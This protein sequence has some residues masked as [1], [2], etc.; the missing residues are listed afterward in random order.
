MPPL[1]AQLFGQL[2]QQQRNAQINQG[3]NGQQQA[4]P[5]PQVFPF[6]AHNF[7]FAPPPFMQ[8]PQQQNAQNQPQGQAGP[9]SMSM[10]PPPFPGMFPLPP[11]TGASP[12]P[13]PRPPVFAGLSDE[14]VAQMEGTQRSAVESRIQA[15]SNISVLLDAAVLQFQQ[16]LSVANAAG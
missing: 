11:L 2:H 16:Y 9:P 7:A 10:P 14:E 3:D 13:F 15:L 12:F 8:P 5:P 6:M 4:Q 1:F